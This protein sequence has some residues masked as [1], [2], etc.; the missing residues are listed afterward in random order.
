[1]EAF[2]IGSVL[3]LCFAIIGLTLLIVGIFFLKKNIK[4]KRQKEQQGYNATINI[5]AMIL[6]SIMI[7]FGAVWFLCFGIGSIV[8]SVLGSSL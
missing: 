8:F 1:M 2:G 6:F 4:W 7:F 3:F 5:I